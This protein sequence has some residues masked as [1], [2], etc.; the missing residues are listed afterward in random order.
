MQCCV[1]SELQ[2]SIHLFH[3]Q[4]RSWKPLVQVL[5]VNIRANRNE[6]CYKADNWYCWCVQDGENTSADENTEDVE[7][8]S[9]SKK[10]S[11]KSQDQEETDGK[12]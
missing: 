11:G 9:S 7:A 4:C 1:P 12:H 2:G 6:S 3:L 5:A 8:P 10:A